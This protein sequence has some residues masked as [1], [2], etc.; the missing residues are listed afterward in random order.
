MRFMVIYKTILLSM[1]TGI[2]CKTFYQIGIYSNC[3]GKANRTQLNIDAG[4]VSDFNKNIIR[5][6]REFQQ[7][8]FPSKY[9]Y[10]F[11][12]EV[13]DVCDNVTHLAEIV[14]NL[15]LHEHYTFQVHDKN[16]VYSSIIDI[17]MH[18]SVE[19]VSFVKSTFN[20]F[21]VHDIDYRVQIDD[22]VY[23]FTNE[24]TRN[25]VALVKYFKWKKI[26]L[27]SLTKTEFPF[28]VYYRKSVEALQK[29]NICLELYDI[30]PHQVNNETRF[31]KRMSDSGEFFVVVLFG[32]LKNQKDFFNTIDHWL[33]TIPFFPITQGK[34]WKWNL[35]H[36]IELDNKVLTEYSKIQDMMLLIANFNFFTAEKYNRLPDRIR[37]AVAVNLNIYFVEMFL[38]KN[39]KSISV[40]LLY[41]IRFTV[42]KIQYQMKNGISNT[43]LSIL[44]G[45]FN[46]KSVMHGGQIFFENESVGSFISSTENYTSC[47][48]PKCRA[49]HHIVYGNSSNGFGW[50]CLLCPKNTY[51]PLSGDGTC[52]KCTGRFNI[53][54]GKRT[55]CT[56]PYMNVH[57]D[58]SNSEF[59]F[60]LGLSFFGALMTSF[61]LIVFV[62]RRKTPIVL[63]SDYKISTIH[64]VIIFLL[65][66]TVPS[67]FIGKPLFDKCILR[68]LSFSVLYVTNIG[69]VFIKSQKLLVAFLSKVKL[70]AEEVKRTKL[71]QAFTIII[72]SI[73][74]NAMLGLCRRYA[75]VISSFE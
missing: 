39:F 60:L 66:V 68:L 52:K 32:T 20:K 2:E 67:T 4:L 40:T 31:L 10:D 42:R 15:S 13:Y 61:S 73:S 5:Q 21:P 6:M 3:A 46:E 54:N 25:L 44:L 30:E 41:V 26:T 57:I 23:D 34:T 17:F 12:Y 72:F 75:E 19:M 63:V 64:M 9:T 36:L 50:K 71:V 35:S 65:F 55:S 22:S 47:E 59:I 29:L 56:D 69:I 14:Q 18:A 37:Y 70:N 1:V 38:L 49:G 16:Y 7:N 58:L 53:D 33:P 48:K 27:V 51:K 8:I 62:I 45:K 28:L 24:M 74:V 11:V 43:T